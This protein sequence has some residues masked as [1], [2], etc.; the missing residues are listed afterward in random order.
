MVH[1]KFGVLFWFSCCFGFGLF[2][3]LGF[4]GWFFFWCLGFLLLL[5]N[6]FAW[7]L[8]L[9]LSLGF[10]PQ[11]K[12]IYKILL[13]E[14]TL[15]FS[16]LSLSL[17]PHKPCKNHHKELK[18]YFPTSMPAAAYYNTCN[19]DNENCFIK[20]HGNYSCVHSA[21]NSSFKRTLIML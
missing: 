10:F 14:E 2:L 15:P 13:G 20:P 1:F 21:H 11:K 19:D 5:L 16:P 8:L 9:Y 17:F 12:G 4:F 6:F 18:A 3:V 7:F